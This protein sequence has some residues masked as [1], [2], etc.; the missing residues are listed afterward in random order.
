MIRIFPEERFWI[1]QAN[2]PGNSSPQQMTAWNLIYDLN[3]LARG[4]ERMEF[5]NILQVRSVALLT[6]VNDSHCLVFA[7]SKDEHSFDPSS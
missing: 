4:G 1:Q 7:I 3:V 5:Y 6:K 2:V